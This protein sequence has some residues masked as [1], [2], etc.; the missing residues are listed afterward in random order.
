MNL[1]QPN[2]NE[3]TRT[4]NRSFFFF[5]FFFFIFFFFFL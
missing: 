3:A 5:F 1:S 4:F 2:S